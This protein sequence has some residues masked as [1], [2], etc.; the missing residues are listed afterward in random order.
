MSPAM[1]GEGGRSDR[2]CSRSK[3]VDA[4]DAITRHGGGVG[5]IQDTREMWVVGSFC[6]RIAR[7]CANG[8]W[9]GRGESNPRPPAWEADILPLNYSRFRMLGDLLAQVAGGVKTLSLVIGH[10]LALLA[11]LVV[12]HWSLVIRLLD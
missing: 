1:G 6:P 5:V 11:S 9:S 3:T 10:W 4:K 12:G 2:N 7:I 8:E